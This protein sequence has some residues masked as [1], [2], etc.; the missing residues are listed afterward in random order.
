MRKVSGFDIIC[1]TI[2]LAIICLICG[3][4]AES[5]G[6]AEMI[7][8]LSVTTL[9]ESGEPESAAPTWS[10]ISGRDIISLMLLRNSGFCIMLA[11]CVRQQRCGTNDDERGAWDGSSPRWGR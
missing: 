10:M 1:L 7:C 9:R 5:C 8:R 3:P 11:I 4:I 2:G 6:L